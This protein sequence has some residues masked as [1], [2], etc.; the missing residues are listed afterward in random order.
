MKNTLAIRRHPAQRAAGFTLLELVVAIALFL[1][2]GL[3]AVQL[4]QRSA[5]VSVGQQAQSALNLTIRNV[6][7]Q[8]Q[9]DLM[10]AGTGYFPTYDI[11]GAP[12]GV[13]VATTSNAAYDTVTILSFNSALVAHPSAALDTTTGSIT[14]TPISPATPSKLA[15]GYSGAEL[16]IFSDTVNSETGR[17]YITTFPVK[18]ASAGTSTVTVT[19]TTANS[20]P[21]PS[22]GACTSG[23]WNTDPLQISTGGANDVG[24]DGNTYCYLLTTFDTTDWVLI[25]QSITYSVNASNQLVRTANGVSAVI[26]DNIL[27]FKVGAMIEGGSTFSYIPSSYSPRN[28]RALRLS[29]LGSSTPDPTNPFQNTLDGGHYRIE[30]ASIMVNPR[31]LSLHD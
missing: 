23:T 21:T 26:A 29:F 18:S 4:T 27:S 13:T 8:L 2:L 25:T 28:I 10:N 7:A 15:A 31:N 24:V 1:V 16:M 11:P 3:A 14:V 30:G 17:P 6:A 19:M 20:L 5:G 12:L 22:T 9:I